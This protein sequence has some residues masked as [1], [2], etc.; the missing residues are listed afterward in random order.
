MGDILHERLDDL[1]EHPHVG[2]VRG[3]GLLAGIELVEDK[4]SRKP[5][6][7]DLRMAETFAE[8]AQ[9][10]GL[11]VWPNSGQADGTNGDLVLIGPP[12]IITEDEISE[13]VRLF[14][15]ALDAATTT[16]ERSRR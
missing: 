3:R 8:A 5:F 16:V 10:V 9:E 14:K 7:R 13:L 2:D 4:A 12:F 15:I 6:D 1:S 11:V